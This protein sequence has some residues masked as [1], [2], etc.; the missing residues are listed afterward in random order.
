MKIILMMF[1]VTGCLANGPQPELAKGT[2]YFDT[3]LSPSPIFKYFG[4]RRQT[5]YGM[6]IDEATMKVCTLSRLEDLEQIPCPD[7]LKER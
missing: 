7:R 4:Q 6:C 5:H 1:L 2:C 3:W